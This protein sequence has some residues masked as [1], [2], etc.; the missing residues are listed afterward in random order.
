MN[1]THVFWT[2]WAPTQIDI[3]MTLSNTILSLRDCILSVPT[4][5]ESNYKDTNCYKQSVSMEFSWQ[6]W[7]CNFRHP[8]NGL[9]SYV[10][11]P[12]LTVTQSQTK[13]G[14]RLF[15]DTVICITIHE[16]IHL[17]KL[18]QTRRFIEDKTTSDN[19]NNKRLFVW[20]HNIHPLYIKA[21]RMLGWSHAILAQSV[22]RHSLQTSCCRN[23]GLFINVSIWIIKLQNRKRERELT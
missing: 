10:G 6:K 5:L 4:C 7:T 2:S 15:V 8:H 1:S 3:V 22:A 20:L 21:N 14:N 16:K 19:G 23:F 9:I 11:R 12:V 13:T 17:I 18:K